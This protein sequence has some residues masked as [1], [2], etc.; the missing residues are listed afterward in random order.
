M[1]HEKSNRISS[2]GGNACVCDDSLQRSAD[3]RICVRCCCV[4][5]GCSRLEALTAESF[6]S[7][8]PAYYDIALSQK[9]LNDKDS[10]EMLDIVFENTCCEFSYMFNG[11][12]GAEI[13]LSVGLNENYASWYASKMKPYNKMLTKMIEKILELD[14]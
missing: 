11:G 5:F 6:R 1:H 8:L 3:R 10:V 14:Y 4:G 12:W 7:V 9:F 13:A 2:S